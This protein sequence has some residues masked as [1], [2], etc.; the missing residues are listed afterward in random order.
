MAEIKIDELLKMLKDSKKRGY[1][2][3]DIVSNPKEGVGLTI[4]DVPKEDSKLHVI[5][6]IAKNS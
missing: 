1:T 2:Y 4:A 3:V 6:Y 5:N